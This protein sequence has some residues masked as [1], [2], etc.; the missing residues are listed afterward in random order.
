[1]VMLVVAAALEDAQGNWLVQQRPAGASHPGLWEFPGGKL[2][3]GE[4]PVDALIRELREELG[5]EADFSSCT[6]VTFSWLGGSDKPVVLLLFRV[7]RW[8]GDP[9]ALHAD[10]IRWVAADML[11]S[12]AMPELDLPLAAAIAQRLPSP[13]HEA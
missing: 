1:M 6:P 9:V 2:E 10:A 11:P 8:S 3:F 7:S 4:T 12:L 5:I 13:S